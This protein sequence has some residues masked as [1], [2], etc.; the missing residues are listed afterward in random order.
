MALHAILAGL[1]AALPG[2]EAFPTVARHE[3]GHLPV[4]NI[5]S[6]IPD[7]ELVEQ[8]NPRTDDHLAAPDKKEPDP[9]ICELGI[10]EEGAPHDEENGS[11]E[12]IEDMEPF[13]A[14]MDPSFMSGW[15]HRR[16]VTP[17]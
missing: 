8:A 2:L 7:M 17:G 15:L 5:L 3:T 4:Q 12:I 11:Q 9:V 6:D 14:F 10:K 16:A 1:A 13:I